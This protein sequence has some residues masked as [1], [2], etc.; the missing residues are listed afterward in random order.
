MVGGGSLLP[1]CKIW[2]W[3][4]GHQGWQQDRT[5]SLWSILPAQLSFLINVTQLEILRNSSENQSTT[6]RSQ[7]LTAKLS[8]FATLH[9]SML[10]LN[11][12]FGAL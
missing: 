8:G 6:Q 5:L 7:M 3:D 12:P 9:V 4:S 1:L 11:P 10:S 2:G